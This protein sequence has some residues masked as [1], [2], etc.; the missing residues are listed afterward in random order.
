MYEI[1]QKFVRLNNLSNNAQN[2]TTT[3]MFNDNQR[4]TAIEHQSL[5][6]YRVNICVTCVKRVT[7]F[8]ENLNRKCSTYI[9]RNGCV[10]ELQVD[11]FAQLS[12]LEIRVILRYYAEITSYQLLLK[13]L[14]LEDYFHTKYIYLQDNYN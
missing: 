10:R 1:F 8:L 9:T 13:T 14:I 4:V 5:K 3:I 6:N 2:N 7:V 12:I 11:F